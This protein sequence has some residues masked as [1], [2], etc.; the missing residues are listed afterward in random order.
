MEIAVDEI[1]NA[2]ADQ[3]NYYCHESEK[4]RCSHLNSIYLDIAVLIASDPSIPNSSTPADED[5][6][7]IQPGDSRPSEILNNCNG[8]CFS[9]ECV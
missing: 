6:I 3:G 5:E 4:C 1:N 7:S 9:E 2:T 8:K